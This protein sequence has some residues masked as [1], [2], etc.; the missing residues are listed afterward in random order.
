[1]SEKLTIAL[2][3]MGGDTGPAKPVGGAVDYSRQTGNKVLL[4][5]QPS[6]LEAA[7]AHVDT[8][9]CDME[10]VPAPQVIEFHD[11]IRAIREKRDSSIHVGIRL[12]RNQK[13]SGFV[14]AGH[15][16]AVMALSK[17]LLGLV[18]GVDRPALP[19]PLPRIGGGSTILLDVGA[20]V[21][22]QPEH[23]RQFAVMGYLYARRFWGIENPRVALLS[24][25]E[26]DSKGN[27]IL[28]EVAGI[29]REAQINFVG[30]VEGNDLVKDRAEVVV[31]DGFVGNVALKVAEGIAEGI[32]SYVKGA[33][34]KSWINR[35]AGLVLLPSFRPL[36]EKI[37]YA[38]YG[39]VPLLGV[40]GVTVVAHGRSNTRAI[41]NA[42]RTAEAAARVD[43]VHHIAR[44]IELLHQTER[45][46]S[47]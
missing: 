29:L 13:A 20:N 16:G 23:F 44:D 39:G 32:T 11:P 43:M 45:R 9:G 33:I 22:C 7:L 37:D 2:D 21:D 14:S 12:V 18:E 31:C 41:C 36:R 19:A 47:E 38:S 1:M 5:G 42:L 25:G 26:E 10:I 30:N 17:V 8:K 35:L 24:I 6:A 40:K 27:Q 34:L 28:R 4:V 3:A 46:L 15:T